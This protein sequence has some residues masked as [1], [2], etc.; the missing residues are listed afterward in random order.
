MTAIDSSPAN[1]E[2]AKSH[3]KHDPKTNRIEYVSTTIG[4]L[5]ILIQIM[6]D[7]LINIFLSSLSLS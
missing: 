7:I 6:M 1:I 3:S 4:L 2:T 5:L